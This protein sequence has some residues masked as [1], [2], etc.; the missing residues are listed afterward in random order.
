MLGEVA[1]MRLFPKPTKL[2]YVGVKRKGSVMLNECFH[3]NSD[4][5]IAIKGVLCP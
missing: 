4:G 1:V 3:K 2:P 5:L